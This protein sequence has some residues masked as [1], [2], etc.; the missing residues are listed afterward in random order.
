MSVNHFGARSP[1]CHLSTWGS[2]P[3]SRA[4]RVY[5]NHSFFGGTT[6]DTVSPRETAV[7]WPPA[8]VLDRRPHDGLSCRIENISSCFDCECRGLM[9]CRDHERSRLRRV[10]LTLSQTSGDVAT[11]R[12]D[13][14]TRQCN[15]YEARGG[16]PIINNNKMTR[17]RIL[18]FA[19]LCNYVSI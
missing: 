8:L 14:T 13:T 12:A 3:A 11:L 16:T 2:I 6:D 1:S 4:P 9:I 17:N 15:L 18:P 10:P 7:S 19:Y 5:W